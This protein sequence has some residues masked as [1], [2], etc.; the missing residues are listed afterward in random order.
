[1][2]F[3]FVLANGALKGYSHEVSIFKGKGLL[4]EKNMRLLGWS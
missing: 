1:M 2:R 3:F 4:T